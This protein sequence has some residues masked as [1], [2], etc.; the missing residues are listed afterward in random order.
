MAGAA[1]LPGS[2][3]RDKDALLESKPPQQPARAMAHRLE[4]VSGKEVPQHLSPA[5]LVSRGKEAPL[6]LLLDKLDK[7]DAW[8]PPPVATPVLLKLLLH[9]P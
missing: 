8:V 1:P 9:I 5:A 3:A 4:A 6:A 2:S 7:K